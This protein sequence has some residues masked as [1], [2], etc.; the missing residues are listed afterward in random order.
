MPA[1]GSKHGQAKLTEENVKDIRNR[2]AEGEAWKSIY[3]SY[4]EI[5]GW[6]TFRSVCRGKTWRDIK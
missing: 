3:E 4:N 5:V 1:K 6:Y 2:I